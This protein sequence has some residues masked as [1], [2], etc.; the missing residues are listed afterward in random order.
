MT[1]VTHWLGTSSE[2]FKKLFGKCNENN[3][4]IKNNL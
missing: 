4:I 1:F 2:I 3:N